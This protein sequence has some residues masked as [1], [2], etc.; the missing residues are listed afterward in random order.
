MDIPSDRRNR[1]HLYWQIM[2][3]TKKT[4]E[5]EK[6]IEVKYGYKGYKSV[7]YNVPNEASRLFLNTGDSMWL[8]LWFL[9]IIINK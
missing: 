9:S 6:E 7:V 8:K 2:Y 5:I 1:H 3:E 4:T